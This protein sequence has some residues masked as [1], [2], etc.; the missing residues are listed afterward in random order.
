MNKSDSIK[1]LATALAKAQGAMA[2]AKMEASNPFLKNKY[3]DLGSVIQAAKGPLSANGLSFSQHPS[4]SDGVLTVTTL[5]MHQSGEWIESALALEVTK[6]NGVSM[7]QSMGAVV[8]YLRR[9]SL[10]SILGMYADEDT[11][12][13]DKDTS[14]SKPAAQPAQPKPEPKPAA[15]APPEPPAREQP[16]DTEWQATA[17]VQPINGKPTRPYSPEIVRQGLSAKCAKQ[18]DF[19][20]SDKQRNMLRFCLSQAFAG[21]AA[22]EDKRRIVL[23]YLTGEEST[24]NVSG[25]WL[26]T[27]L[28]EWL[29]PTQDSGGEYKIDT[30]AAK[31]AQ[32]I[33]TSALIGEGQ[34]TL[35]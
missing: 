33:V 25:P 9:Y 4:L 20:P 18:R 30:M 26:K 15:S 1:E 19:Q 17:E 23:D 6:G 5:L 10:A 22:A 12:G 21:D 24:K 3:A 34:Q 27:I 16:G 2:P 29:K 7:A 31:E 28:D 35:I 14:K 13:N 8:T 32:A 11:D